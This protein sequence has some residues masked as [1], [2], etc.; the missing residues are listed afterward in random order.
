MR[1]RVGF[2]V[3]CLHVYVNPYPQA[4][5][6]T[7]VLA[8]VG[9]GLI[10]DPHQGTVSTLCPSTAVSRRDRFQD[11]EW[12]TSCENRFLVAPRED[13]DAGDV[14]DVGRTLDRETF[15][16]PNGIRQK[17]SFSFLRSLLL[18]SLAV[19]AFF[20]TTYTPR[21]YQRSRGRG[22]S[23][24]CHF[25]VHFS[26]LRLSPSF[27][28][29][30]TSDA[31][32]FTHGHDPSSHFSSAERVVAPFSSSP[33]HLS[34]ER[35]A[36]SA[37]WGPFL[38]AAAWLDEEEIF[39]QKDSEDDLADEYSTTLDAY[40]PTSPR[41]S[42]VDRECLDP[43][44]E[45]K[46]SL[47]EPD[48]AGAR[49]ILK[50]AIKKRDDGQV[51]AL[52]TGGVRRQWGLTA[53]QKARC[54]FALLRQFRHTPRFSLDQ[55]EK[56][57]ENGREIPRSS[58]SHGNEV[59][60]FFTGEDGADYGEEGRSKGHGSPPSSEGYS[61]VAEE[62][63]LLDFDGEEG[64]RRR[65]DDVQPKNGRLSQL[66]K[67][68]WTAAISGAIVAGAAGSTGD[69]MAETRAATWVGE[70]VALRSGVFSMRGDMV[71]GFFPFREPDG[72]V[73]P[74][75]EDT[76]Q[77]TLLSQA[78]HY[79]RNPVYRSRLL[80]GAGVA[81]GLA[82]FLWYWKRKRRQKRHGFRRRRLGQ[83]WDLDTCSFSFR[84][85]EAAR[86]KLISGRVYVE[87]VRVSANRWSQ[88]L[89]LDFKTTPSL[90]VS[91]WRTLFRKPIRRVE[92]VKIPTHTCFFNISR[93]EQ[94]PDADTARVDLVDL[95][96]RAA[97]VDLRQQGKLAGKK[98]KTPGALSH[99]DKPPKKKNRQK[100]V[101]RE[102]L[103]KRRRDA[104]GIEGQIEEDEKGRHGKR[105][106][107]GHSTLSKQSG[108][109]SSARS[110]T[111]RYE[112]YND[113]PGRGLPRNASHPSLSSR[114]NVHELESLQQRQRQMKS[115]L[116][117]NSKDSTLLSHAIQSEGVH[118][119]LEEEPM[120]GNKSNAQG[121]EHAIRRVEE[122]ESTEQQHGTLK[123]SSQE[124]DRDVH[125]G[126]E[127]SSS[128]VVRRLQGDELDEVPN[129]MAYERFLEGLQKRTDRLTRAGKAGSFY[130]TIESHD[131]P[132][133]AMAVYV[134]F[135]RSPRP[136]YFPIGPGR[137]WRAADRDVILKIL[138]S[139]KPALG[140]WSQ[141][142]TCSY[143]F[144]QPWGDGVV[145]NQVQVDYANR[146][147]RAV[148]EKA[149]RSANQK[150]KR[151][152]G[153]TTSFPTATLS[154]PIK[155]GVRCDM[156]NPLDISVTRSVATYDV[157]RRPRNASG[158]DKRQRSKAKALKVKVSAVIVGFPEA[159]ESLNYFMPL[160][161]RTH[162]HSIR[163]PL[164]HD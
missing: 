87:E 32:S 62:E 2:S 7:P 61:I 142:G 150:N 5:R 140:M 45:D 8:M 161:R 34:G 9:R 96:F 53:G 60:V 56:G 125:D 154:Y 126:D 107:D 23:L 47:K 90:A 88:L 163:S 98:R 59:E 26:S 73:S 149:T 129:E 80:L 29:S 74:F 3:S 63:G 152:R 21:L 146:S 43:Q 72:E 156:D 151:S 117:S 67:V 46:T 148:L 16:S 122:D 24:L 118:P 135:N 112:E 97:E 35:S 49:S 115:I 18:V 71:D 143:A 100:N 79:M 109:G 13:T 92:Y 132:Q 130:D 141:I 136:L 137:P 78:K 99:T 133:F 102:V 55:P 54:V 51:A 164:S 157:R 110:Q 103:P 42:P 155:T 101:T 25:R 145:V 68:A 94:G 14:Q 4:G 40:S 66:G 120:E 116:E 48:N 37:G 70:P 123:N 95:A 76:S 33:C 1:E 86:L 134:Y 41:E 82:T 84:P 65:Q 22:V 12:K 36:A 11:F 159:A 127:E 158:E 113:Y 50:T 121:W 160:P 28:S 20:H 19:L 75:V 57:V 111:Q 119:S 139:R 30:R 52:L 147:L 131:D 124:A 83:R 93:S 15:L 162:L 6:Q 91:F 105:S 144:V 89:L 10:L 31:N 38:F 81:A 27:F 138:E 153:G 39:F 64:G 17:T 85:D 44:S 58:S 106:L 128:H 108:V 77:D 114:K 69:A 104:G